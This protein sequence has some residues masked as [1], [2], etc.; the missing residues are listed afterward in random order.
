VSV[1]YYTAF[2]ISLNYFQLL[3]CEGDAVSSRH[4]T[5]D[6]KWRRVLDHHQHRLCGIF[7]LRGHGTRLSTCHACSRSTQSTGNV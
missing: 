5:W 7:V 1:L 6:G 2:N 3:S 4:H